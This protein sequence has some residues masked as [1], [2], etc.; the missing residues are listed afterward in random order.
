MTVLTT[1]DPKLKSIDPFSTEYWAPASKTTKMEPP[2][3]PLD[4]LK[5]SAS[6]MNT[7]S[8]AKTVKPFFTVASDFP[9]ASGPQALAQIQ[10]TQNSASTKQD[11]SKSDKPKK[12]LPPEDMELFRNEVRGSDLSKVGMIEVLKKKFP[13]RTAAQVKG[14][15]ETFGSRVGKK[16][17]DKRWVLVDEVA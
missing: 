13:Q 14:T 12:L 11:K 15:L 17:V 4:A 6:A 7:P 10:S 1:A 5:P 3:I 8:S 16:E 9:K 2:R